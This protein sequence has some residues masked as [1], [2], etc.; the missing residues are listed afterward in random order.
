[1]IGRVFFPIF[2]YQKHG[3]LLTDVRSISYGG[4]LVYGAFRKKKINWIRKKDFQGYQVGKFSVST[5][6]IDWIVRLKF[7]GM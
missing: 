5:I 2:F 6:K 7:N 3:N 1:M 4:M